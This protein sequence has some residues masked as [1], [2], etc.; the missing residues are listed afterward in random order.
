M[1]HATVTSMV[2]LMVAQA[3]IEK[4]SEAGGPVAPTWVRLDVRDKTL[5][6]IV[7]G[8][9]AQG[10]EMLAIRTEPRVSPR[11]ARPRPP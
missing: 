6:E 1:W 3:R 4:A 11:E 7:D 5:A 2:L 10:P 9:N 8:I